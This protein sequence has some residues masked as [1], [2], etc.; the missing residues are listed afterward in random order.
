MDQDTYIVEMLDDRWVLRLNGHM[1]ASFGDRAHAE[2]A[3]S[4]AMRMSQAR[5]HAAE[6]RIRDGQNEEPI[7]S[8]APTL[9]TRIAGLWPEL[10]SVA[11][12]ILRFAA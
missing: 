10:V 4:V 2:R 7:S 3:A 6:I 11:A 9:P 12:R 8:A 5:G 1:L